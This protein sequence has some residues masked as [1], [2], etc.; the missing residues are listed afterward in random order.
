MLVKNIHAL[1]L[2]RPTPTQFTDVNGTAF[3]VASDSTVVSGLWKSDG[4]EAGTVLVSDVKPAISW[5]SPGGLANINGTLFFSGNDGT[6]GYELWK[7]DGSTAG[8][9]MVKDLLE[10]NDHTYGPASLTEV[11]G[12]AFF[13][14]PYNGPDGL[15]RSD[16]T[17]EGTIQLSDMPVRRMI[18][19]NGTLYFSAWDA[20]HG[21]E[22]WKSNGSV[23]GTVLVK[24]IRPGSADANVYVMANVN[25]TLFFDAND[26]THGPELWK[27]DGSEDGTQLVRDI[28][29]GPG[30]R[31]SIRCATSTASCSSPLTTP[32]TATNCGKAT[33]AKRAR[34]WSRISTRVPPTRDRTI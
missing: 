23:E 19:V 9:V 17:E 31:S 11:N 4:T 22:L 13:T 33:A 34:P 20:A 12:L 32:T 27:S 24:D 14:Y 1:K 26:G 5:F 3:F 16:G 28:I 15:W 25:G 30:A 2:G 18:N 29:P 6:H 8:T 21:Y 7:S 10:T